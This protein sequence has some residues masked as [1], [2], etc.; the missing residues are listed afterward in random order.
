MAGSTSRAALTGTFR[1]N[2]PMGRSRKRLTTSM[3]ASTSLSAGVRR[4]SRRC[5]ASV[6]TT[7]R[8]VRLSSLTP[9]RPSNRRT[10]SLRPDAL[11]PTARAPSRKP[12]ALATATNA[13]KSARSIFIVR[14]SAQP[15]QILRS[16]RTAR[17]VLFCPASDRENDMSSRKVP[18][19]YELGDRRVNRLGYGAMQLAGPGVFGPPKDRDA[20]LAVLR[21]AVER[22]VNHIDTSDF[23]GPHVTN[24]LI[25]EA[26]H[27]Y[28]DD[29]VIVTKVGARRGTD[30]SWLPAMSRQEL[31]DAVH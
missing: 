29:L 18:H 1:R 27:P 4:S 17:Q 2:V 20:A 14:N 10:A 19:A 11:P 9:S 3:A 15:V 25:R 13:S 22:G 16:C 28:R 21:A 31:T 8:V 5:P 23:Y 26:L 24:R 7:L 12:L 30:G 6:G